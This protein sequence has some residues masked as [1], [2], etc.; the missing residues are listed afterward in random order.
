MAWRHGAVG[1][2]KGSDMT[3]E[4]DP[5]N[6]TFVDE[7][8]HKILAAS[9]FAVIGIATVAYRLLEDWSWVDSLYFSVVAVTT[10]GF[11]DLTPTTDASKLFTIAYILVGIALI[12]TFLRVS[13]NYRAKKRLA[14]G[15]SP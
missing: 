15:S 8:A 4:R 2:Q 6:P 14:G 12:A 13:L 9:A 7:H 1:D 10:V 3:D 5:N 11:G